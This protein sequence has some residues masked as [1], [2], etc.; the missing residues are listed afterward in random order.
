[1]VCHFIPMIIRRL[2][3]SVFLLVVPVVFISCDEKKGK[4]ENEESKQPEKSTQPEKPSVSEVPNTQKVVKK[5]TVSLIQKSRIAQARAVCMSI[6]MAVQNFFQDYNFLP[7]GDAEKSP[8]EDMV[9]KSDDPLIS[10]LTG[11][12]KEINARMIV[13]LQ[14][15]K[16]SGDNESG[17]RNGI[18][19]DGDKSSIYDP[20]G[21]LY[22]IALD[23]DYDNKIQHPFKEGVVIRKQAFVYSAGPDGEVGSPEKD[24]DNVTSE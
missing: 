10:V 12:E 5:P 11:K 17:Y 6:D 16:A 24:R 7:F 2:C 18:H 13:F 23:F 14:V 1:M 20:W 3:L 22:H 21:N 15:R 4:A 8:E 19:T 9:I